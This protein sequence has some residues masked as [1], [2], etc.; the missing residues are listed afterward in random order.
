MSH[1]TLCLLSHR[2]C[3]F[4]VFKRDLFVCRGGSLT[5]WKAVMRAEQTT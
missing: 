1:G 4:I 2:L 3:F 5:S